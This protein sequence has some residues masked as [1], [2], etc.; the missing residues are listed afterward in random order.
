MS[1]KISFDNLEEFSIPLSE[2]PRKWVFLEE[3]KVLSPEFED[4]IIALNIEVAKFL[5]DFE[6][7]QKILH[8]K[9]VDANGF[10]N[11]E[12]Y[13]TSG[14]TQK[15][16][17]KWLYERGI[18]FETKVFWVPSNNHA[19]ILTWKMVIKFADIIFWANDEI[20]WDQTLNWA[21]KYNHNNIFYFGKDR[22]YN[23]DKQSEEIGE[24]NQLLK[25]WMGKSN[26][27]TSMNE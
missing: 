19:F 5:W 18:P 6:G 1:S 12:E 23:A 7:S 11:K 3:G 25:E 22:I 27:N 13:R 21:L 26:K 20:I 8:N 9:F 17:K 16:I 4:Q 10:K 14:K 2:H 15:E 24:R